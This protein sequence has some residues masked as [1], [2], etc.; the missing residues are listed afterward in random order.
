MN[1]N[2]YIK[3]KADNKEKLKFADTDKMKENKY[4]KAEADVNTSKKLVTE[5]IDVPKKTEAVKVETKDTLDEVI[6]KSINMPLYV[7]V[8]ARHDGEDV[9]FKGV[10]KEMKCGYIT[11]RLTNN[12][13]ITIP[14]LKV[15]EIRHWE[16][17]NDME[18]FIKENSIEE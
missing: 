11:I 9:F 13:N 8:I 1:K 10:L 12:C 3:S 14:M 4:I 16:N 7:S 15:N 2:K 5:I 17:M 18:R 6:R